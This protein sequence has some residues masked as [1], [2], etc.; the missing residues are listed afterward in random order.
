M[1]LFRRKNEAMLG[2]D[3]S[4]TAVKLL[5]FARAGKGYRVVSYS[6]VPLP[7]DSVIDK[8]IVNID[9]VAGA[10][11]QSVKKARTSATSAVVAVSGS[12]VINKIMQ[13]PANLKGDE[14]EQ[15]VLLEA[16][17]H[18][19]YSSEEVHMD[20]EVLGPTEGDPDMMD[21]LLSASR[22]EYV[23]TRISALERA[24]LKAA[25][26]DIEA[27]ALENAC[28]LLRHQMP[29]AG[30]AKTIAV[31]DIGASMTSF[32]VLHDL[33]SVYVRDQVFGGRQLTDSIMER[34]G[35]T[36]AEAGRAK[37]TGEGLPE[38]YQDEVIQPFLDDLVH[39]VNRSMQL[40]LSASAKHSHVD[41]VI[42]A[43]GT[44]Q[45]SRTVEVIA[46]RLGVPVCVADPFGQM[47]IDAKAKPKVLQSDAP[48]MLIA[49]G[50]A[51]RAFG[52]ERD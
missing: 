35:L 8:Q 21:V 13:M 44:A 38:G 43:G 4:S 2:I 14:L 42:L 28:D 37:K 27:F 7:A 32:T 40:F 48:A 15:M 10:I 29:T 34:Y 1:S 22:S 47:K 23:D 50:L 12:A 17:Q 49:A 33:K 52:P 25:I 24:G 31:F 46:E 36:F 39:M 51:M 41:E 30:D 3:I 20:F 6:V 19:P 26:V 16:D 5:E 11:R 45:M 9:A 18:I